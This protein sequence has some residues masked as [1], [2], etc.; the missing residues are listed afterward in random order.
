[1]LVPRGQRQRRHQDEG[2]LAV[3]P[4]RAQ[5]AVQIRASP[6]A[7]RPAGTRLGSA[8]ASRAAGAANAGVVVGGEAPGLLR[9]LC[10]RAAA[11][12]AEQLPVRLH[13]KARHALLGRQ[14]GRPL[15]R[16]VRRDIILQLL[17]QL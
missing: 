5:H 6:S 14:H 9:R 1:M 11:A 13:A 10:R 8:A 2:L 7:L 16:A 12:A 17:E 3:A 15:R 4:R